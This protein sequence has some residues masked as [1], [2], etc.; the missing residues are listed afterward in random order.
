MKRSFFF[1]VILLTALGLSGCMKKDCGCDPDSE[2]TEILPPVVFQYEYYNYAWGFR[3]QGFLIDHNGHVKGFQQPKKWISMDSSGMIS[4]A[5]LEFNL[6]QCDTV[7]G[8]VEFNVLEDYYLKIKDIRYGKIAD[9]GMVMA[10]AGT[11]VLS[12]WY[13]N[14]KAW[15]YENVF[16]ISNSDVYRINTHHDVKEMVDWLRKIGE[17]TPWFYWYGGI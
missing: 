14:E 7:C 10:D 2:L 16:L 8:K 1:P 12:A 9:N 11:G 6:A 13:W 4:K 17:K 15:K 3:H 5:D